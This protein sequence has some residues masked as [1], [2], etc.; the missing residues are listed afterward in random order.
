[1]HYLLAR[2]KEHQKEDVYRIYVTD[3]L[4]YQADNKRLNQRYSDLLNKKIESRSAEQI[5]DEVFNKAGLTVI[6]G[7]QNNNI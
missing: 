1:M 5:I 2:F 6:K 4:F 7:E 3:S